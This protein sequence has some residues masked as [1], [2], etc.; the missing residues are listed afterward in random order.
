MLSQLLAILAPLIIAVGAGFIWGK[1]QPNFPSEF[2]SRLVMNIGTP[3]LI[4]SAMA[5]VN[6]APSVIGEVA[7]ASALAML[8]TGLA[9][10]AIIREPSGTGTSNS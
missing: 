8:L 3:S 6:V 2:V 5:K 10:A 7:L 4:I 9:A 1:I